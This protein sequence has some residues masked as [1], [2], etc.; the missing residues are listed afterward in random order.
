MKFARGPVVIALAA[1]AAVAIPL[2][3][4]A[5]DDPQPVASAPVT[6]AGLAAD[7]AAALPAP[8]AGLAD[9]PENQAE[10][11]AIAAGEL[12]LVR[13]EAPAGT[14][15][16]APTVEAARAAR[17]AALDAVLAGQDARVQELAGRL[18]AA[19]SRA[20]LEIQREIEQ[21]KKE[22]GRRLLEVQLE[23]ATNAGDQATVENLQAAIADWDAPLPVRQPVE[24][25]VPHNQVR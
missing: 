10:A 3:V 22:T 7:G 23:M 19:D 17:R 9:L 5:A 25:P 18:A 8:A 12:K 1:I 6:A 15:A 20:A 13:P 24:R 4:Q 11:A 16:E 21:V 2:S 14:T